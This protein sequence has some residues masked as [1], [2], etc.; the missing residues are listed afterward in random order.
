MTDLPLVDHAQIERLKEWGGAKLQQKM[1]DL[2]LTHARERLDQI[3]SGISAA[4]SDAAETGAHTLKSSAGNVGARQVQQL[5]EEAEALAEAGN[6]ADLGSML[7]ML[8]EAFEAA[9]SA[10]VDV[11]DGVEE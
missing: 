10:L 1:I 4:D 6:L 2:F 5:A 8:E 11:R 7:P 9:C 3:K